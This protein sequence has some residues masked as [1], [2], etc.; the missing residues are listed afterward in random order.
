MIAEILLI[1]LSGVA[2]VFDLEYRKIPNLVIATGIFC[3][4]VLCQEPKTILIRCIGIVFVFLFGMFQLMGMGDLKL[5]MAIV[6]FVGFSRSCFIIVGAAILLLG[7]AWFF[8]PGS[9]QTIKLT[10]RQLSL[11][12]V[13]V[14][15]QKEFPFAP[16]I[17]AS[18]VLYGILRSLHVC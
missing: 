1:V 15:E 17:F 11:K 2:A 16:F 10:L 12:N 9:K 4:L 8:V 14:F 13:Q 18:C 5:W 3:G 7:Y 6:A